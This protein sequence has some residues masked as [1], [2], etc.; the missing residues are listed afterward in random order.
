M[1]DDISKWL[2]KRVQEIEERNTDPADPRAE[3]ARQ[4][5]TSLR[6]AMGG[7]QEV[8]KLGYPQAAEVLFKW[9]AKPFSEYEG[10]DASW[11][12]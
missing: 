8:A 12:P 10:Y 2:L 1:G 7:A 4:L 11:A 5:A 6:Y 3:D 9:A